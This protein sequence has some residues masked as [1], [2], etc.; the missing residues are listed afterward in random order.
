MFSWH[1]L[2]NYDIFKYT[3]VYF[4]DKVKMKNQK[5]KERV[6]FICKNNSARSQMAEGLLKSIYG[7]NF[8]VYSAGSNPGSVNPYAVKVLEEVGVNISDNRSKSLKEF[9]GF[10]FNYVVT[11][12]VGEGE[13]CPFFHGGKTYLHK[14]FEDPAAV[15]GTD[16]E[17][18]DAFRKI[19]D[20]IKEWIKVTFY[21]GE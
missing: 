12:C 18:T 7:K 3:D 6:L 10:E 14:S 20:E 16:H 11:V 9:E 19:R 2:Y 1:L 4:I 8:D 17:K 5:T 13:A 21:R 15:D